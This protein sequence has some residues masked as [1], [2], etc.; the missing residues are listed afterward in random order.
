MQLQAAFHGLQLC[1]Q[2]NQSQQIGLELPQ[3]IWIYNFLTEPSQRAE[4]DHILA[5][6]PA[7]ALAPNKL[8][9]EHLL[10]LL[11]SQTPP[12]EFADDTTVAGVC[13]A[14]RLTNPLALHRAGLCW[15]T[16]AKVSWI[17]VVRSEIRP[18]FILDGQKPWPDSPQLGLRSTF[19][20]L[21]SR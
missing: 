15:C 11:Y 14:C 16:I 6:L 2:H 7:S 18:R 1:F 13:V 17:S 12:P 4:E 5:Q 10:L 9:A 19:A 8:R 21:S 20:S 3:H